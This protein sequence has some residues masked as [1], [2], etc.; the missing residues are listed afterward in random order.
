[1][2]THYRI[3]QFLAQ[4]CL[5]T[6]LHDSSGIISDF[7]GKPGGSA[8]NILRDNTQVEGLG[9]V[10]K[11]PSTN[12]ED[13]LHCS[14]ESTQP[15]CAPV[16]YWHSLLTTALFTA[17]SPFP[18]PLSLL[19]FSTSWYSPQNIICTQVLALG[20]TCFWGNLNRDRCA[21]HTQGNGKWLETFWWLT[22]KAF[23]SKPPL[24]RVLCFVC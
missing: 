19:P 9:I 21:I 11:Y 14:S 7:S 3:W 24:M 1:M 16:A 12:S 8:F 13:N 18:I 20:A 10:D 5:S 4:L 2:E 23:Y 6:C 15:D 17:S 22:T